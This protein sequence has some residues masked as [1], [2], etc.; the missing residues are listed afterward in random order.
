MPNHVYNTI[1]VE[2]KYISKLESLLNTDDKGWKGGGLF[3]S[4]HPMPKDLDISS[5][6]Y[7]D[8]LQ[9]I[10]EQNKKNY[11]HPDWYSWRCD[12]KNWGNK[13]GDYDGYYEEGRYQF[14]TA[15]ST[16]SVEFLMRLAKIIPNFEIHFEEEQ[17]WGGHYIFENG[18]I[19][20]EH[21][22]DIPDWEWIDHEEISKLKEDFIG[23]EREIYDAGYYA[24]GSFHEWLGETFEEAEENYNKMFIHAK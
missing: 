4:V 13:W 16:P 24:H 22:Y 1:E 14:C 19:T 2:E 17:G 12:D 5:P 7:G 6:Q 3:Q 21:F 8:K 23:P 15:W 20:D 10:A 9:V 11:G 18:E